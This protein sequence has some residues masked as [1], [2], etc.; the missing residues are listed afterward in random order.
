[1]VSISIFTIKERDPRDDP[2]EKDDE[3]AGF[4]SF[5]S[6]VWQSI[7]RL[8]GPIR[9][10]CEIQFFNWMGWF[11]FLFY[12]TTYIGQLYVNP[13]LR[14]DMTP[15]EVDALWGRATR[16]GTF[17]LLIEAIVSLSTNVLL[18]FLIIPT[19][20]P[21]GSFPAI[22]P[23][24]P[25]ATKTPFSTEAGRQRPAH[26]RT[27]STYSVGA[28][29]GLFAEFGAQS[30]RSKVGFIERVLSKMQIPG[31][32]LRRAWLLAQLIFALCMFSTFF[33]NDSTLATV[34]VAIV[35]VSWS[36]TLWAP[37]ALIS[38][39]ISR[40]DE[41]RRI[42]QRQKLI[43]GN[44][45]SF[46]DEEDL[47]EDRAGIILGLHNVAVSAPQVIATL[48]CSIIFKFLQKPRSVPGDTSVAWSL[49][50]AGVA[51]L[52]AAYFTYARLRESV[53]V[54]DDEEE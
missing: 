10:V 31:F 41:E 1:M 46:Y 43:N 14:P 36:L 51:A 19:Y 54:D 15:E 2:V 3:D 9:V 52:V 30:K 24:T 23:T 4:F 44:A 22:T 29:M 26:K 25:I 7:K 53:A 27:T 38:A 47:E 11:P 21:K 17:A 16:I 45:N 8:P 40:K 39:E 6:N 18:P 28:D 33:I 37:F 5:F 34:M 32:T 48:I 49:R 20:K 42:K 12:I 50:L 35:G 13:R